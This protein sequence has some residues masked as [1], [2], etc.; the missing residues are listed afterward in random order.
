MGRGYVGGS[1]SWRGCGVVSGGCSLVRWWWSAYD[2]V[3]EVRRKTMQH[4][5]DDGLS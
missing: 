5:C 3:L 1:G 4:M 2:V